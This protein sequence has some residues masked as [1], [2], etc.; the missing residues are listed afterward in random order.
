MKIVAASRSTYGWTILLAVIAAMSL[1]S[2]ATLS[3]L[4]PNPVS[5]EPAT[6]TPTSTPSDTPIPAQPNKSAAVTVGII[7]KIDGET[8]SLQTLEGAI[9][10]HLTVDSVILEFANS[11]P[12]DL[13][14]GQRVTRESPPA[15]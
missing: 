2:C 4:K 10:V 3:E 6:Q 15:P 9:P 5:V 11:S 14:V 13:A 12:R 1:R 7:G 8:I